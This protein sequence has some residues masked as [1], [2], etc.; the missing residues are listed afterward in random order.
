MPP[1]RRRIEQDLRAEQRRDARGLGVPLV[2][3]DQNADVREAGFPLPVEPEAAEPP[4]TP[5]LA[6]GLLPLL[7]ATKTDPG[8][9]PG[10]GLT[11]V[12]AP[13]EGSRLGSTT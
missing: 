10:N 1:D 5:K 12:N 4:L 7:L 9:P 13:A 11:E 2:P 3:T 6:P 8:T